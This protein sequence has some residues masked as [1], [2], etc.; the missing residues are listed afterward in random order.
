ML[1]L[2]PVGQTSILLLRAANEYL[3][4]YLRNGPASPHPGGPRV[5]WASRVCAWAAA[6]T[7]TVTGME[8][9]GWGLPLAPIALTFA[10]FRRV[11]LPDTIERER[12]ESILA[13]VIRLAMPHAWI[14][15]EKLYAAGSFRLSDITID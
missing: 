11:C 2:S 9:G 14:K 6:T 15:G 1:I 7:S 10:P 4:F 3:I 8:E 13:C 12:L 5:A